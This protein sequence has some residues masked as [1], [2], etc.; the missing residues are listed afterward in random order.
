MSSARAIG[1]LGVVL[2]AAAGSLAQPYGLDTPEPL[3]PYLGG[4]FPDSAPGGVTS[5]GVTNAFPNLTFRDPIELI[6]L[7]SGDFL[8]VG[9]AGELWVIPNDPGTTSKTK[10]L[11]IQPAVIQQPDGGLLGAVL[12][13]EFG[14]PGSPNREFIY[15]Y[16]RYTPVPG[17]TGLNA[18]CR[19][20]RFVLDENTGLVDPASEFVM[21]QQYDRHDWHNGGDMFFHP[22]DGFLYLTVGDEGGVNDNYDSTQ[23]IDDGLFSGVLRIDVD[24][25]LSRSHPIRRQPQNP[26][27]PPNGWPGSFTQGYTIPNDNPWLDPGGGVL[28]EFWAIGLRS[29]HRMTYD[30]VLDQIWIGDVGQGSREE[31]SIAT[32]GSNMQWPYR[33][34][35]ID[36]AH[37]KPD[38]LIGFDN[39]PVHAYPR[40]TGVCVI[41]GFVYRGTKWEASLGGKYL[42]AD[43]SV[44]NVWSLTQTG[45]DPQIDFM[46]NV[47]ASG[48][49]GKNGISSFATDSA[50]EVYILKL[51]GT[52]LDGGLIYKL[53]ASGGVPDPPG[54]LSQLG[55]FSDLS[56]LTPVQG[57]VP[58][59][60]NTPLW[61]DRAAKYRWFGVPN[62]GTHDTAGEQIAAPAY[63]DWRFPEGTLFVKH[64]ELPLDERDPLLTTRLETRVL[65]PRCELG[66]HLGR[67]RH[68]D[69]PDFAVL[70]AE[71]RVALRA[72]GDD[73]REIA[74]VM[75][76]RQC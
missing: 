14:Q 76:E 54:W 46:V 15:L 34:G 17:H 48:V 33:E 20:S 16:Y 2:F 21:I 56:T 55:L 24:M 28:E 62:D 63:G 32:K 12:H 37:P 72:Q 68:H 11:D 25:D 75:G 47:P 18:Y 57:F 67:E 58:Y 19:L 4:V 7:P 42:F 49:G 22:V 8:I 45:G 10:I 9:K 71:A 5:W 60:V 43:H 69:E 29:P 30:P 73:A 26:G 52:D 64:F 41:G 44:R 40:S 23:K 1:L 51:F 39:P 53:T 65:L 35:N 38:P 70:G 36:G 50:G 3:T 59:R 31:V 61:S 74:L 27:N 66:D 6:E 13:P